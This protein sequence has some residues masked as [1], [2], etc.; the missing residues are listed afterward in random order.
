MLRPVEDD[1]YRTRHCNDP[2]ISQYSRPPE[3]A[4]DRHTSI[5]PRTAP[6]SLAWHFATYL[7]IF[8]A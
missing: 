1:S 2:M 7:P 5:D 8:S 4:V 3:L 6:T